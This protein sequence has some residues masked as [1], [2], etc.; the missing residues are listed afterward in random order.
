MAKTEQKLRQVAGKVVSLEI[1]I[2][3]LSAR[4]E[5]E[6]ERASEGVEAE[7]ESAETRDVAD[8]AGGDLAGERNSGEAEDGDTVVLAL[9]TGPLARGLL[10]G[11]PEESTAAH[12]GA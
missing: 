11:V 9:Y 1:E 4:G 12:G 8:G 5:I 2:A 3:E 7:A 6:G 10:G